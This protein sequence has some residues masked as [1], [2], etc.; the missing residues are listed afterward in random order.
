[1]RACK[2]TMEGM[3]GESPEGME[4]Q[5]FGRIR[6]KVEKTQVRPGETAPDG[7]KTK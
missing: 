7:D 3:G 2:H 1:M 5:R 4:D 6:A